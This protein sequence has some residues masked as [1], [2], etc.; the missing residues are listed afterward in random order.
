MGPDMLEGLRTERVI[1]SRLNG[2][3]FRVL[4]FGT[5]F[6]DHMLTMDFA[7]GAWGN[8]V[9]R[10][11]GPLPV[12]PGTMALHYAQSIFEGLK[13]YRDLNGGVRLFRPDMN[14]R[15]MQDSARFL[16][17]EP[18]PDGW[19]EAAL[20][21][22]LKVDADWV[23]DLPEHA[24]YI[25]PMM[26]SAEE[27]LEVRPSTRYRFVVIGSPVGA[28]FDAD[29]AGL[30]LIVETEMCRVPPGSGMGAAKAA[31]NYTIS[32][33][34]SRQAISQGFDQVLWLDGVERRYI[35]EAGLMNFFA[36][37]DGVVR[38]P[39]LNGD[40]LPGVTRASIL[41]ILADEGVPAEE[42]PIAIDEIADAAG[43]GKL[44]EMFA[45]GTAAVVTPIA[46]VTCRGDRIAPTETGAGPIVEHLH[47]T[48]TDIQYGRGP[49]P[50]GW[51]RLVVPGAGAQAAE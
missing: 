17:L 7:D 22:Y 16:A 33:R 37:I 31:A 27:H 11:Y 28:Y 43:K 40:I 10:P 19:F 6:T 23:P 14:A 35:D 50:H 47:S 20:E 29:S 18:L 30:N 49:D 25:R 9:I 46:S 3:D 44:S 38:T 34:A 8:P 36:V 39:P 48:L 1:A 24:L 4:K 5:V 21:A 45:A 12:E 15:R 42:S 32:L 51:S 13:A 41:Q 2:I 26:F